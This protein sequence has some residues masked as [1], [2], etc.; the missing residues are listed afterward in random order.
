M[1]VSQLPDT[2]CHKEMEL[3]PLSQKAFMRCPTI[4]LPRQQDILSRCFQDV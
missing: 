1:A 3:D 4:V 2:I